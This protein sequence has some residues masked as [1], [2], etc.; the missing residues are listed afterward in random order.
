MQVNEGSADIWEREMYVENSLTILASSSRPLRTSQRGLSG[1][2][3]KPTNC[4]IDGTAPM[5]SIYLQ[6]YEQSVN[7]THQ[8]HICSS[9]YIVVFII[10]Y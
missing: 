10:L 5:P 9:V 4:I 3:Q 8:I 2:K 6:R 1:M 7:D